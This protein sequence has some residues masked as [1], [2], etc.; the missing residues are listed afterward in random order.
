MSKMLRATIVFS[1]ISSVGMAA[2]LTAAMIAGLEPFFALICSLVVVSVAAAV[3]VRST[4][5][6]LPKSVFAAGFGAILV[7]GFF[8]SCAIFLINDNAVPVIL[9]TKNLLERSNAREAFDSMLRANPDFRPLIWP[10]P[11]PSAYAD[12]PSALFGH[13]STLADVALDL[14]KALARVGYSKVSY[15]Y[16][17]Y[18]FV[19]VTG[20][21][22]IKD[23]GSPLDTASRWF[24]EP[25]IE[26]FS[27]AG[28]LRLL[29]RAPIGRYR[30]IVFVFTTENYSFDGIQ[31]TR[32]DLTAISKGGILRLPDLYRSVIFDRRYRGEA[33]IYEFQGRAGSEPVLVNPSAISGNDHL[34]RAHI[35]SAL[36]GALQ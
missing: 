12:L 31:I 19:I 28:Y 5:K 8:L 29:L 21:E 23:D 35:W 36:T 15:F 20:I 27:L 1:A 14:E 34:K 7:T 18:G 30:A 33:L 32:Y 26:E 17:P 13:G 16:V 9:K 6:E 22:Q 11:A 2:A 3:Y 25:A 10:P 4:R 24:A